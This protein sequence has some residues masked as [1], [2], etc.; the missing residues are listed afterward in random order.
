MRGERHSKTKR[1]MNDVASGIVEGR[2]ATIV[3]KHTI[4]PNR[5]TGEAKCDNS[6]SAHSCLD[7]SRLHRHVPR[8]LGTSVLGT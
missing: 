2:N 8:L 7:L 6:N 5:A 4:S 1:T 3:W